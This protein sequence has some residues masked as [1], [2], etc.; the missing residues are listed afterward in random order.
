MQPLKN[1]VVLSHSRT[2]AAYS[3]TA[4][5]LSQALAQSHRVFYIERP[6]TWKDIAAQWG[7]PAVRSRRTMLSGRPYFYRRPEWP[8]LFT[9]ISLPPFLPVNFLPPGMA[10]DLPNAYN[11]RLLWQAIRAIRSRH[12]LTDWAF[13]NVYYPYLGFQFP[14]DLQPRLKIYYSVDDISQNAYTGK[15]GTGGEVRMARAYDRVLATSQTLHQKM[16]QSD[17][18]TFL[19]PN[20]ADVGLFSQAAT[21]SFQRP[22]DMPQPG[23]PCVGYVGNIDASRNDF[24][25]LALLARTCPEI[26]IALI[27]PLTSA[28]EA[29]AA[30]LHQLPNVFFLGSKPMTALPAYLQHMQAMLIPFLCNTLTRSIYPLKINEYLAAG[31]PVVTTAFSE[32]IRSFG[33]VVALAHTH[34]EF[35]AGVQ[36][37]LAHDS[38]REAERRRQVAAQNTWEARAEQL[39]SLLAAAG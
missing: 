13:M 16:S 5:S 6:F 1:I 25:L 39:L 22:P 9:A 17:A 33:Q 37:A 4:L 8:E 38:P 21:H 19:L 3:S 7:S 23:R 15:H 31:K 2:D 18:S 32:D 12:S 30:G 26:N 20:A 35:V 29:Q 10:Y 24:A 14:A 27:G 11:E 34:Q 28:P 36:H